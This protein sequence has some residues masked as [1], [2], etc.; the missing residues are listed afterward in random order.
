MYFP[1]ISSFDIFDFPTSSDQG[2]VEADSGHLVTVWVSVG[3]PILALVITILVLIRQY[4]ARVIQLCDTIAQ[5]L[6]RFMH[7]F[8]CI[9]DLIAPPVVVAPASPPAADVALP[10]NLSD[11]ERIAMQPCA[12]G[13][14]WI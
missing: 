9:H 2:S 14:Q 5:L 1:N 6:D 13:G 12:G 4:M 8:D 10:R 3:C 11:S 7:L